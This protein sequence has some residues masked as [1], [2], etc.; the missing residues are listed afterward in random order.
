MSALLNC[1]SHPPITWRRL[2]YRLFKT[3]WSSIL[4]GTTVASTAT[5]LL[6]MTGT[7]LDWLSLMCSSKTWS[8][9]SHQKRTRCV[10]RRRPFGLGPGSMAANVR[11]YGILVSACCS[12]YRLTLCLLYRAGKGTIVY[13]SATLQLSLLETIVRAAVQTISR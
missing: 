2:L 11:C 13:G 10:R 5:V 4:Q 8:T 7:S 6:P 12:A 9:S 3:T 1:L